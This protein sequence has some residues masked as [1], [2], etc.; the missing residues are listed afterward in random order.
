[1]HLHPPKYLYCTLQAT[2]ESTLAI[3]PYLQCTLLYYISII[4]MQANE[5]NV[6]SH[7]V[8]RRSVAR[9]ALHLGLDSMSE[10]ALDVLG[11]VL[12]TY[13]QRVSLLLV[14]QLFSLCMYVYVL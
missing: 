8:A 12:L 14:S 11:D 4:T 5:D 3:D 9:A 7:Q 6:Y 13:L 10:E 1:V 2:T